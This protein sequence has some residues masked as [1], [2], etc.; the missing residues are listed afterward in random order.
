MDF[1]NIQNEAVRK[2]ISHHSIKHPLKIANINSIGFLKNSRNIQ[3][4]NAH[5]GST[6][7]LIV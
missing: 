1:L 2:M 4:Q 7:N 5:Q 6:G 3:S